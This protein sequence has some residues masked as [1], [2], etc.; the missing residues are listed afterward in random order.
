MERW[1]KVPLEQISVLVNQRYQQHNRLKRLGP[2]ECQ[3]KEKLDWVLVSPKGASTGSISSRGTY[4][5]PAS[6]AS[7]VLGVP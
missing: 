1:Q 4:L 7:T 2:S 5:L 6:T 3:G